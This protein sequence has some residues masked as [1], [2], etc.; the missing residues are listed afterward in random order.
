MSYMILLSIM[1]VDFYLLSSES[2][3]EV[4]L[5]AL[6]LSDEGVELFFYLLEVLALVSDFVSG[7]GGGVL[8]PFL[9]VLAAFLFLNVVDRFWN[10]DPRFPGNPQLL[11]GLRMI[12]VF[13]SDRSLRYIVIK[14]NSRHMNLRRF[15]L[16]HSS[17]SLS[18]FD[19]KNFYLIANIS[20]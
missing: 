15:L 13:N 19:N 5:A 2:K 10:D 9:S 16:G 7:L 11:I 17:I 8:H 4:F 18:P 3:Y 6:F 20:G 12:P 1:K 14:S